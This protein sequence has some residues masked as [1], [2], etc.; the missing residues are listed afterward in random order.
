[1]EQKE[2]VLWT[3]HSGVWLLL[4]TEQIERIHEFCSSAVNAAGTADFLFPTWKY[5]PGSLFWVFLVKEWREVTFM[6]WNPCVSSSFLTQNI[7]Y[8]TVRSCYSFAFILTLS[9]RKKYDNYKVF[10]QVSTI[11]NMN[12]FSLLR[13][14]N[15]IFHFYFVSDYEIEMFTKKNFWSA[16]SNLRYNYLYNYHLFFT[17]FQYHS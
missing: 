10:S 12:L 15:D 2:Q 9:K 4:V 14:R 13:N 8:M 7:M 6:K 1:M 16:L 3:T 5:V 17:G 11:A